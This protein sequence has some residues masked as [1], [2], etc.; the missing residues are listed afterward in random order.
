[1]W[2][3][4]S[5]LLGY[6]PAKSEFIVQIGKSK[7][8]ISSIELNN[9]EYVPFRT[10]FSTFSNSTSLVAT[11][12]CGNFFVLISS[13]NEQNLI[14]LNIPVFCKNGIEYVPIRSF[15]S[16]LSKQ[17]DF[18]YDIIDNK[19]FIYL[20]EKFN[21]FFQQEK[22][23]VEKNDAEIQAK[24]QKKNANKNYENK[25][26]I[27][28]KPV[29]LIKKNLNIDMIDATVNKICRLDTIK[30]VKMMDTAAVPNRKYSIP[31]TLIKKKLEEL[32]TN[33]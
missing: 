15:I 1:M 20:S 14:Q 18:Q 31:N 5:V 3:G 12:N 23:A 17:F 13:Q 11:C 27:Q 29:M 24:I 9:T 10:L 25:F 28:E 4:I 2:I 33:D 6:Y 26:I 32:K 7:T 19:L 22:I 16:A 21:D 30:K 8:Q